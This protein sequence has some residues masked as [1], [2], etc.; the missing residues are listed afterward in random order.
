[1][2]K[3]TNFF[4]VISVILLVLVSVASTSDYWENFLP[5]Q[6]GSLLWSVVF[7]FSTA[8]VGLLAVSLVM[9]VVLMFLGKK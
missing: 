6:E 5:F 8:G 1:M 3:S 9:F 7:F 4:G 2:Q